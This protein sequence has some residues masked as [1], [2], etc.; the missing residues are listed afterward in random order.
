MTQE[1][2]H[3]IPSSSDRQMCIRNDVPRAPELSVKLLNPNPSTMDFYIPSL[4][5]RHTISTKDSFSTH[6]NEIQVKLLG[7]FQLSQRT[8]LYFPVLKFL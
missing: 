1:E 7:N 8:I 4:V 6:T 2:I 3:Y 5:G